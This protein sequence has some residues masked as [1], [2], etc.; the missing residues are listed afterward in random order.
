VRSQRRAISLIKDERKKEL[1][2]IFL[3]GGVAA[4]APLRALIKDISEKNS[5]NF[6][7]PDMEFCTDNAAMIGAACSLRLKNN[8][9]PTTDINS[10]S[11]SALPRFPLYEL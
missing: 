2:S 9:I 10:Y 3:S 5:L 7:V 6:L 4:N 8:I 11:F 1:K